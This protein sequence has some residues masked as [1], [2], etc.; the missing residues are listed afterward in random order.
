MFGVPISDILS[1][2]GICI[3]GILMYWSGHRRRLPHPKQDWPQQ[4]IFN[5]KFHHLEKMIR[6]LRKDNKFVGDRLR[7]F[8]STIDILS[9]E[10]GRALDSLKEAEAQRKSLEA[11]F[12]QEKA[13]SQELRSKIG[14]L[15]T[16]TDSE[17]KASEKYLGQI[18]GYLETIKT[19]RTRLQSYEPKISKMRLEHEKSEED[20]NSQIDVLKATISGLED[21]TKQSNPAIIKRLEDEIS[22]L[23]NGQSDLQ[24]EK[25]ILENGSRD[26][27]EKL[28][29]ADADKKSLLEK[30]AKAQT[31]EADLSTLRNQHTELQSTVQSLQL[32]IQLADKTKDGLQEQFRNRDAEMQEYKATA[33]NQI[34]S[35]S[36]EIQRLQANT[37]QIKEGL[38]EQLRKKDVEM[39][40]YKRTAED[41]ISGQSAEMQQLQAN[42][43][44]VKNGLQ[45]QLRKK[46]AEM[47][48][49]KTI[50]E[51]HIDGQSAEIQRLQAKVDAQE[52]ELMFLGVNT[53]GEDMD[54]S[55]EPVASGDSFPTTA[56]NNQGPATFD[57]NGNVIPF[58][59]GS[60]FSPPQPMASQG[61]FQPGSSTFSFDPVAQGNPGQG[62]FDF[63]T[64]ASQFTNIPG[65]NPQSDQ[66]GVFDPFTNTYAPTEGTLPDTLPQNAASGSGPTNE[67]APNGQG[68]D[69][70]DPNKPLD[71][72]FASLPDFPQ[73]N[74]GAGNSN[75]PSLQETLDRLRALSELAPKP[76]GSAASPTASNTID[77]GHDPRVSPV[78]NLSNSNDPPIDPQI[79]G[80]SIHTPASPAKNPASGP[81]SP[82]GRPIRIP[83]GRSKLR[84]SMSAS[85][86]RKPGNIVTAYPPTSPKGGEDVFDFDTYI[87]NDLLNEGPVSGPPSP[88]K[89]S[90]IKDQDDNEGN[91]IGWEDVI[92]RPNVTTSPTTSDLFNELFG[93]GS[94]DEKEKNG[95]N[96]KDKDK[97]QDQDQDKDSVPITPGSPTSSN[98]GGDTAVPNPEEKFTKERADALKKKEETEG[99][100]EE[101]KMDEEI[102]E[103]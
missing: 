43:D 91:G 17:S 87:D 31:S 6:E 14:Q 74:T 73:Q 59:S 32:A 28:E 58:T 16:Q 83:K 84:N 33:Q 30:L 39:Q 100:D 9:A 40:E 13:N 2:I 7:D 75:V 95:D 92:S 77:Q 76:E 78:S 20:L 48:E 19:L 35:Q 66:K 53:G 24:A 61:D 85:P 88:G 81:T 1:L 44:Q 36:A 22:S 18:D 86:T 34:D 62:D 54:I 38:Q 37:D 72:D 12:K 55:T 51:G 65:L 94:S 99:G 41:R 93:E 25:R 79:T 26:L 10:K 90:P 46:D 64:D 71:I 68:E 80:G 52:L 56:P 97:N 69:Q 47:Q 49:Y 8:I 29:Q 60:H 15:K 45:E 101:D 3:F 21:T 96:D 67:P 63:S 82:S 70:Y 5:D 102:K 50:A 89:L 23:R 57:E 98:G 27:R 11:D 4:T 103:D 42:G